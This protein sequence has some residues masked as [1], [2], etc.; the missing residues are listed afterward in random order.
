MGIH[1]KDAVIQDDHD[2]I[3]DNA[4][5]AGKHDV[6]AVSNLLRAKKWFRR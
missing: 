3:G 6:N 1:D 5:Q 4:L 2:G